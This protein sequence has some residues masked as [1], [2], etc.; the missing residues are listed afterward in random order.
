MKNES[1]FPYTLADLRL[2]EKATIDSF[3][4]GE[5]SVKLLEMGCLPGEQ[6]ELKNIAPLGDPIAIY[7]SGY[8][9]GLRKAEA[10]SVLIRRSL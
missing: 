10:S 8:I 5:L 2:G 7:V 6:V 3:T 4:D 9:L 1:T